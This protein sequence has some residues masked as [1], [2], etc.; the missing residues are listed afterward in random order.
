MSEKNKKAGAPAQTHANMLTTGAIAMVAGIVSLP[1]SLPI[2]VG[3]IT[4]GGV[5]MCLNLIGISKHDNVIRKIEEIIY[6]N[7]VKNS[8]DYYLSIDKVLPT[9]NGIE[10]KFKIPVGLSYKDIEKIIPAISCALDGKDIVQ[11]KDSIF[12]KFV[13]LLTE[14]ELI[15]PPIPRSQRNKLITYVGEG[16][17]GPVKMDLS[18][19]GGILLAGQTGS[20]KSTILRY[21]LTHIASNYKENE[22]NIFLNDLKF[23]ELALFKNLKITKWHNTSPELV[24]ESLEDFWKEIQNRYK[25]FEKNNCIDCYEYERTT[26]K[27]VPINL[28]IIEEF[29]I[30]SGNKYKKEI[31]LLN[32]ILSQCRASKSHVIITTQRPDAKTLD[33]RLKANITH[34]I[35]LKTK[36]IINSQIICDEDCL[37]HLRG[38]GHGFLFDKEKTE[39]QGYYLTPEIAKELLTNHST[40]DK[41]IE[42]DNYKVK[43][44]KSLINNLKKVAKNIIEDGD[45]F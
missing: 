15:F 26:G 1:Y 3:S 25:E 5:A 8:I 12:I 27:K 43:E 35:G 11:E 36:S 21:M 10:V 20:G 39:F 2:G 19:A 16:I 29:T 4:L 30:L 6:V 41:Y 14:Y 45:E 31:E 7:G 28:M 42:V 33:P 17:E 13:D 38:A 34:T 37:K 32:N 24:G 23:T 9:I 40:K 18:Q 22:I 44:N